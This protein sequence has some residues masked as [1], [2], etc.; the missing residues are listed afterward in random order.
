MTDWLISTLRTYPELA[1]FVALAIGFWVGPKKLG[2]FSLGNVTAT[3]L[4][5]IVVGQLG[6]TVDGPIKSAFFLLFLFAVGYGVGPQFF[7]GLSKEGPRQIIFALIVCLLCL[8]SVVGV[9][10]FGGFDVGYATGIYAG[11]QTISASIGPSGTDTVS[12]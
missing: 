5:A 3:L 4:A 10:M 11:S 1:I 12:S 7:A 9:S 2:G 6:M 8:F